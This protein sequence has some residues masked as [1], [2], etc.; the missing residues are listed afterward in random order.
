MSQL[1]DRIGRVRLSD[2]QNDFSDQRMKKPP[3]E[4]KAL[5]VVLRLNEMD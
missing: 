1:A 5:E 2:T 3:V 4:V